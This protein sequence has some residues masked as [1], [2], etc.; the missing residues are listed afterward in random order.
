MS[1][2]QS[3]ESVLFELVVLLVIIEIA[4][5]ICE[6]KN[7]NKLSRYFSEKY[8]ECLISKHLFKS[9]LVLNTC[10]IYSIFFI[11]LQ[12]TFLPH[13]IG[14]DYQTQ[15]CFILGNVVEI[16]KRSKFLTKLQGVVFEGS[17]IKF[18]QMI[19]RLEVL[20]PFSQLFY[21]ANICNSIM[22]IINLNRIIENHEL[23]R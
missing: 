13:T 1:V 23:H 17:Q 15:T 5:I 10:L 3:V 20:L 16:I 12:A 21:I 18:D 11:E 8:V 2:F 19:H 7:I 22:K 6:I 4:I 9:K 14:F